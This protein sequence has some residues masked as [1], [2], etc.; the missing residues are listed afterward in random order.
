MSKMPR[1]KPMQMKTIPQS[2]ASRRLSHVELSA[3]VV[4]LPV[5]GG[6]ATSHADADSGGTSTVEPGGI[7][8]WD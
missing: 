7:G 2:M 5:A 8:D 4:G 3:V 6:T 1:A